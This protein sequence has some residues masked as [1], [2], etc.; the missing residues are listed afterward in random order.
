MRKSDTEAAIPLVWQQWRAATCQPTKS[1][2]A[3]MVT[4]SLS[5][6]GQRGP[7]YCPF[8]HNGDRWQIVHAWLRRA[9]LVAD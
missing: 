4:C 9:R 8:R 5:I 2:L 6:F 3:P 1:R 7:T